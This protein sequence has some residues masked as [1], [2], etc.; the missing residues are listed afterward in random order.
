MKEEQIKQLD[1]IQTDE[2]IQD[3]EDTEKEIKDYNDELEILLRN[4]TKNRTRIYIIGG[5]ISAR[6]DFVKKLNKIIDYRKNK[7]K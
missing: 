6:N 7:T 5:H 3:K 1:H 4:R 2:I